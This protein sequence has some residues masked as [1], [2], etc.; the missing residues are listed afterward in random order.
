MKRTK[1]EGVPLKRIEPGDGGDSQDG[2][3]V[4]CWLSRR[5]GRDTYTAAKVKNLTS[6]IKRRNR[7][8]PTLLYL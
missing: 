2:R 1:Q 4:V 5:P 6:S 7:Y 3:Y 8:P